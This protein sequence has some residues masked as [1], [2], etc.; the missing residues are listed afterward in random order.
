MY[1]DDD[2]DE[3]GD[4]NIDKNDDNDDD[5]CEH[6]IYTMPY[7]SSKIRHIPWIMVLTAC[8]SD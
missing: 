1:D 2:D 6:L 7:I 4:G 5:D 3:D 8:R